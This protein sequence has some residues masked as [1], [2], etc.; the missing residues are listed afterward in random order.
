MH[1]SLL[2]L[3]LLSASPVVAQESE[4][5]ASD[6]TAAEGTEEQPNGYSAR[7]SKTGYTDERPRFGGPTSPEG[8]IVETDTE[9]DPAFRFPKIDAA[10]QPWRIGRS[11]Q[12][13]K[14]S[15]QYLH[16]IRPCFKV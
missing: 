4:E 14:K 13:T 11:G 6:E 7:R 1:K 12:I 15:S 10:M 3:L 5:T 9:L 2:L 8:E 16:T